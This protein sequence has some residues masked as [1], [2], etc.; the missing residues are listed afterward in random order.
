MDPR[1][2]RPLGFEDFF[3]ELDALG[4]AIQADPDE[5]AALNGR[6]ELEMKPESVPGLLERFDLVIGEP[7]AGGWLSP[8]SAVAS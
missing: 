5:L 4:G 7:L 1:D 3:R 8:A 6:Y 2:H